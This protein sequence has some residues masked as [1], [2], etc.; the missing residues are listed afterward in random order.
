MT[1]TLIGAW[2]LTVRA[3][4]DAVAL[5]DAATDRRWSRA[6]LSALGAAW[7]AEYRARVRGQIVMFAEVNGPEWF[8]IFLGL[9]DAGAVVVALD[10]GEPPAAQQAMARSIGAGFLWCDG[11]LEAIRPRRGPSRSHTRL[12]K[13]TSGSTGLPRALRFTDAHMLADG[14]QVCASMDVRAEDVNLGCIPLGHSYGLGNLVLP[15]LVQGTAMVTGALVLPQVL[16]AA[17]ARWRPTVF[18]SVPALLRGLAEAEIA[19]GQ[20]DS[21]RTVISA[22]APLRAEVAQAFAQRFQ[23][24]VHSF[25]GS[26]ETGGITYDRTGEATLTGRSVGS[27]LEGVRLKFEGRQ[28]FRVE[29]AAVLGR[30][31]FLPADRGELNEHGELVLLGRAGRMLK[32]AGRRLDPAEVERALRALPGVTDAFVGVHAGRADALAAVVASRESGATLREQLQGKIAAW[33]IPKR[34]VVLPEF[35]VTAR[36][37]TDTRQLRALLAGV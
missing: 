14:R 24:K 18:P 29:S 13:L 5:L 32:I 6:E 23:R 15:L 2:Q 36:G 4:P 30:G 21:L 33:K 25:Y 37:K 27:P 19:P 16:A 3:A 28:R 1:E 10:P 26:S 9:L 34:L 12:I 11:R 7:S 22:G 17:I 20:L 31:S 35:P 8:R